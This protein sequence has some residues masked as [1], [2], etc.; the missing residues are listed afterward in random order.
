MRSALMAGAAGLIL[1][2]CGVDP[3]PREGGT[4]ADIGVEPVP[5]SGERH[6][7]VQVVI[8]GV[9]ES[10]C[11]STSASSQIRTRDD[12]ARSPAERMQAGAGNC[13]IA[14][15]LIVYNIPLR[16]GAGGV[17]VAEDGRNTREYPE[18]LL[19]WQTPFAE[20]RLLLASSDGVCGD[21]SGYAV[22]GTW[23]VIRGDTIF[24]ESLELEA[25]D[26]VF[27]PI[28]GH[29]YRFPRIYWNTALTAPMNVDSPPPP[30]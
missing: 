9:A 22:G 18:H 29:T 21:R 16:E 7:Y 23:R 8:D 12:G 14:A 11:S 5:C 17:L 25:R 2:A 20:L 28:D 24:G 15:Q 13:E 4:G 1:C 19:D 6:A 3:A 30:R 10:F 26:I 27:D